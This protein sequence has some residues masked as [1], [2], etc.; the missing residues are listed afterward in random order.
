VCIHAVCW[1]GDTW[2]GHK[3]VPGLPSQR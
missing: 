2:T 1:L 3:T